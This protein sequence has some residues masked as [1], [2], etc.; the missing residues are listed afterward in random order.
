MTRA[1]PETEATIDD[2]A[3]SQWARA[4]AHI[5]RHYRLACSP[6]TIQASAPWFQGKNKTLAL[7]Q[8]ARQAGLSF[9]SGNASGQTF[10][11]WRLPIIA[12][13]KDGQLI[14]IEHFNGEDALD[15]FVIEEEG[16]RN[17][18]SLAELLP[19]I[20]CVAAL[21][22]LSALKD[23][24]VDSYVSRFKPDWMRELVLQDLRPYLPVMVAAFLIN[25]LSLAGIVFSMQVY[26]RVIPAQSY[27]TLYVLS[28]GVLVAVLFGFLL[29]EARTHIMD[30]L[31]KRADMRISDRVFGHALRLRNSAVPRS[32]GSFISQLRELEQIREMI[33]SSTMS[34]IVDLPFFFLFIVVLA[35]IAPPLAWIAP[36]A[37]L[38]MIL[39]GL[40]LQKKLAVLANQAAHESTLRNAVLVESVQGLEDIKLMQAENRFLQQWNSY[41]RITGES[42]LRTRK[43]TQGLI[44]WG[45]SVQSLVYAAVIMFGAPMV[46]EGT[47]TTG[48]VVAASMLGS[49]MIAPMANLCG[50]LA[51][52]QQVKAAKM[53][54]DSIMQ[55]PTETQRDESLVH[56][57][58]FHGHYLFENAHFRYHNDDQ[59]VPLR[60]SRLEITP[61]E[62]VAILGRNGAGKSTM[63]QAMAGGVELIQGDVRLDNLSLTQIDMADLR[64]N[65]GFLSQ[66]ARLF[67]G[68]LR[69]NLTLGAPHASDEQIFAV[70]EVS[71]A[72]AFVKRLSKGLDH[73]VMEGGNGLS[74]GQRQSILLA[75]MLLRSPNIVLL[76]E[77]SASLD[78]HTEREFI[79][80]LNQW[81]GNRTLIV[82]THR[83]PVLELVERVVVLKEGQLVMDAP[84]A[85]ALSG[86]R[87]PAQA[88][89][90]EWKN[91]NQSA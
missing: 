19:E 18:L 44:G 80:R 32:T 8:L 89:G 7:T 52:W 64:R 17:R 77:P 53:G 1:A 42:G 28:T 84:K 72:A 82:A 70:L 2:R 21:R 13:L 73:P 86:A 16:Q 85:Q 6:G 38:L 68:T 9:H 51:R 45:M 71:G 27:P 10:S 60:I 62:R 61:G 12:E 26:D 59:R 43:L 33:T 75:R 20:A 3:L 34:T 47:M 22:P 65:I 50:V 83:V 39:P 48:S 41:I 4:I 57:E 23:S 25:V 79:Q 66:N 78:E 69:E 90:R 24:R 46:I 30:V 91:E 67:F 54:L 74:G 31:G 76:D 29:R 36:V 49:R 35:I 56:Q 58:I 15:I 55:L 11:Q 88:N 87:A 5:A 40:L 37:A 63:L 14:V 81:L